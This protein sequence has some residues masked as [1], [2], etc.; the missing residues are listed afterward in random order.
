MSLAHLKPRAQANTLFN[1]L[2]NR[3]GGNALVRVCRLVI[4]I[5]VSPSLFHSGDRF[6]FACLATSPVDVESWR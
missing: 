4:E 3:L 2:R 5:L 1:Y 6:V